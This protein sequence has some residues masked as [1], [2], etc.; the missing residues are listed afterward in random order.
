M[1]ECFPGGGE[2]R[3]LRDGGEDVMVD[4]KGMYRRL[5]KIW[6]DGG[7]TRGYCKKIAKT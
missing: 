5:K 4:I 3:T 2:P 7:Y 6:A 1:V